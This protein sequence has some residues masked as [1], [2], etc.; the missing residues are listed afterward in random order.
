MYNERQAAPGTPRAPPRFPLVPARS[1]A[2]EH[3]HGPGED[4]YRTSIR[5]N[6]D[7]EQLHSNSDLGAG[8]SSQEASSVLRVGV[9]NQR[10][11]AAA[12]GGAPR[13]SH[14][15]RLSLL[16]ATSPSAA[17][18]H[19]AGGPG[20]DLRHTIRVR[21]MRIRSVLPGGAVEGAAGGSV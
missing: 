17:A 16:P 4:L 9:Y 18:E 8:G 12:P 13:S 5:A 2:A 10:Q 19:R 15:P 11:E 7:D 14:D 20:E 21:R 6:P 1:A 3:L